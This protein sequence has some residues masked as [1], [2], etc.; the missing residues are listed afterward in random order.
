[1][2]AKAEWLIRTGRAKSYLD[3]CSKLSKMRQKKAPRQEVK[4][5][6]P[7]KD[8]DECPSAGNYWDR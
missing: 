5:R 7:Y 2:D 6:L 3:A 4:A 1:L 8:D